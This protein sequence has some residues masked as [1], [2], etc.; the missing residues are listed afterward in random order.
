M[1][2]FLVELISNGEVLRLQAVTFFIPIRAPVALKT[3]LSKPFQN[4]Y[5]RREVI[6]EAMGQLSNNSY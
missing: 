4:V 5:L 1:F 6:L 2:V 3:S